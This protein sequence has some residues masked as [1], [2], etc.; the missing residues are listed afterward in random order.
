MLARERTEFLVD[1]DVKRGWMH[2]YCTSAK[3]YL[4][5][6]IF[7]FFIFK[8]ANVILKKLI[9]NGF[10]KYAAFLEAIQ[11]FALK[12]LNVS[13]FIFHRQLTDITICIAGYAL[14]RVIHLIQSKILFWKP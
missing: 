1:C 14:L 13:N 3:S 7:F 4:E 2:V 12:S 6:Q 11:K 9:L 10:S 8:V 5:N